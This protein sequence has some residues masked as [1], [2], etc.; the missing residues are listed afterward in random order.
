MDRFFTVLQIF[1]FPFL[2]AYTASGQNAISQWTLQESIRYAIEHNIS[3]QQT[4]LNERLAKLQM[5]QLQLSQLPSVQASMGYGKS[6]GRSIDPTS[7]QF[8]NSNYDFMSI[9]GSADVLLFGWFQRRNSISAS[10]LNLEST[11]EDLNQ[12]INDVSLNVATGFL[13]ALLAKEQI[14]ISEQQISLSRAQLDQTRK[15]VASGRLPELNAAQM[16]A[17]LASDSANYVNAV[18]SY[19]SAIIDIKALLNLDFETDYTPIAPN[20][21]QDSYFSFD[22]PL[23]SEIFEIARKNWGAIRSSELKH[24]AAMK[25]LASARGALWPQLGLSL[26]MGSNYS[27]TYSEIANYQM[28][29]PQPNGSFIKVNDSLFFPVYEPVM[30]YTTRRVPFSRQLDNN[31]RQTVSLGL[32]I[33]LFNSWKAQ[34]NVQQS[35]IAVFSTQ[36]DQYQ[37]ELKLKQDIY[38]AYNDALNAIKKYRA[39]E[40][41][42]VSAERAF[43]L[44]EK[45]Y[46]LGLTNTVEYLTIQNNHFV[47]SS[48]LL[49]ARYDLIF[50]LKVIDYYLGKEIKL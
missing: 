35:K 46:E 29:V 4:V 15:F 31:F 44:A 42:A 34:H 8:V 12:L 10:K 32:N 13:R 30:Q 14:H 27:G 39:A 49:S 28:G 38:R 47:A 6:F 45:R 11:R 20:L 33:P 9:A 40:A 5:K 17:Q 18:A 43:Y 37:S 24:Q 50:K 25:R 19:N 16:E 22:I 48:N 36:L 41:A 26:Q 7:N 23:P 1:I 2:C 21:S 3:I